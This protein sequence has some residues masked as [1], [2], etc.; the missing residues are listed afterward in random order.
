MTPR[1]MVLAVLMILVAGT[2][3]L[4][5]PPEPERE[6]IYNLAGVLANNPPFADMHFV[7]A[8]L[9]CARQGIPATEKCPAAGYSFIYPKTFYLLLPTGL[10]DR[11]T[12]P[13]AVLVLVGFVASMFAFMRPLTWKQGFYVT[14]LLCAPP[15]TLALERGNVDLA[16]VS[17]VAMASLCLEA[18]RWSTL[19]LSAITVAALMKIYPI[20]ALA[21]AAGRVKRSHLLAAAS[22]CILGL[23]VQAEHLRFIN[24][25]LNRTTLLSWG[26]PVAFMRLRPW[27]QGQGLERLLPEGIEHLLQIAAPA[28]CVL[29]AADI[30]RRGCKP[31]SEMTGSPGMV[32]GSSLYCFCWLAGPN[33]EYRYLVLLLTLPFL[34]NASGRPLKTFASLALAAMAPMFWLSLSYDDLIPKLIQETLGLVVFCSL[35]TMLLMFAW[36]T[37]QQPR[38]R[39]LAF[40]TRR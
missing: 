11:Q 7:L 38:V 17:L 5:R 2:L 23:G 22:A 4:S 27:L 30:I 37:M 9:D 14:A 29:L 1:Y 31:L 6:R 26:Y 3:F 10:S 13:A 28:L 40:A 15:T 20:A 25:N 12:L 35:L 24:A 21:S 33:F 18:R 19:A 32:A 39:Q 16:V 8:S 36:Q 34:F